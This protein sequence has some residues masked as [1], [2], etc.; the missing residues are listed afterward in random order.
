MCGKAEEKNTIPFMS[1]KQLDLLKLV[2]SVL[3]N[4]HEILVFSHA[5]FN[6]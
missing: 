6:R 3:E 1:A 4:R 2:S 5:G